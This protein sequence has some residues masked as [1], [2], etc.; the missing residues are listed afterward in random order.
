[1][2]EIDGMFVVDPPVWSIDCASGSV[3]CLCYS[4]YGNQVALSSDPGEVS[5]YSIYDGN[6]L[7][8][9][10]QTYTNYQI[11]NVHYHPVEENLLLASSKDGF[12]L[13]F[14]IYTGE[15]TSFSRH[16]GSNLLTMNIDTYGETFAIGCADGSIRI[17]DLENLQRTKALVKMTGRG[18]GSTSMI[19]TLLY[20]PDDSNIIISTSGSDRILFWDVRTGNSERSLIGA[21]VR[22]NGIDIYQNSI[23]TASFRD[24]KQLEV[25]DFGTAKKIRDFN[26]D[27][28]S[29]TKQANL[30]C[31]SVAKNGLNV[32]AGGAVTNQAQAFDFSKG[33]SIGFSKP[34]NSQITNI[35]MSPFGSSFV[36]GTEN[37]SVQCYAIRVNQ[38]TA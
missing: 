18:A 27:P 24:C 16:L 12:M 35:A 3:N 7:T 30:N 37:G 9:L 17:Y 31:V 28:P 4:N 10:K 2:F 32:V 22:G 34:G 23:I 6:H 20:Y 14:D 38:N 11:T 29:G 13:L 19:Y 8:T 26:F 21:H 1:M 15:I 36:L 33:N 5:I 25:W